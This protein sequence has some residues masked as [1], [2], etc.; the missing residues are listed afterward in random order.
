MLWLHI[1]NRIKKK[2]KIWTLSA[3]FNAKFLLETAAS[4]P[5]YNSNN[6]FG[7]ACV[8][9]R[10]AEP[11]LCRLLRNITKPCARHAECVHACRFVNSAAET[12]NCARCLPPVVSKQLL[13]SSDSALCQQFF[14]SSCE[15]RRYQRMCVKTISG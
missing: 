5:P 3:H 10:N 7:M 6:H 4:K 9:S 1:Q 11:P 8:T 2:K 15:S 13:D 14:H 12:I